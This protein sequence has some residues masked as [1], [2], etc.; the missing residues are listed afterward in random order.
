MDSGEPNAE[1]FLHYSRTR[2]R[3]VRRGLVVGT[4]ISAAVSSGLYL[5]WRGYLQ[6]R[7]Q[8]VVRCRLAGRVD[9]SRILT[10]R[11][12][13]ALAWAIGEDPGAAYRFAKG[14]LAI[15]G[16]VLFG[17]TPDDAEVRVRCPLEYSGDHLNIHL[18]VTNRTQNWMLLPTVSGLFQGGGDT[19][20]EEVVA[21]LVFVQGGWLSSSAVML[22]PGAQGEYALRLRAPKR[23][24]PLQLT[25]MALGSGS[26]P[27][28]ATYELY[29]KERGEKRERWEL[30]ETTD[31]E[32]R[33]MTK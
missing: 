19:S 32:V 15:D 28:G 10:D 13:A 12:L 21:G 11:R 33:R 2:R 18:I 20:Y 4:L 26:H 24:M 30:L 27:E 1:V 3:T 5:A 16:L 23:P 17:S 31:F 7:A 6:P 14:N 9:W 25:L 29:L 22:A 8:A